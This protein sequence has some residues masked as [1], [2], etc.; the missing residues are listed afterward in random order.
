MAEKA[1]KKVL[2]LSYAEFGQ[3]TVVLAVIHEL[4][5]R[6]DFEVH[7]ASYLPALSRLQEVLDANRDSYPSAQVLKFEDVSSI[8]DQPTVVF[9][10]LK[11]LSIGELLDKNGIHENL[12]HP[13]GIKGAVQG[14]TDIQEFLFSYTG[15]EYIEGID[16]CLEVIKR[17][18]PLLTVV[19]AT[20][21]FG[22]DA[23]EQL[24]ERYAMLSPISYFYTCNQEQ[25]GGAMLWKYPAS[26][27]PNPECH[28]QLTE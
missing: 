11:G 26:V 15:E 8:P 24:K 25:R 14:Y 12:P 17:V 4:L 3:T 13:P 23:C 22:Q 18:E 5:L 9:H 7:W 28:L 6:G 20:F 10:T 21:S 1:K 27:L 19:D 2:F 16:T